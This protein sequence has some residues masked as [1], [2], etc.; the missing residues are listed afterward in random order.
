MVAVSWSSLHLTKMWMLVGIAD[1]LFCATVPV[2]AAGDT[3]PPLDR[4]SPLPPLHFPLDQRGPEAV[5]SLE[6]LRSTSSASS[7]QICTCLVAISPTL[8]KRTKVCESALWFTLMLTHQGP[9]MFPFADGTCCSVSLQDGL[10]HHIYTQ[11][12]EGGVMGPACV[13]VVCMA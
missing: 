6:H 4:L 9:G 2:P 11:V 13:C 12:M 1:G 5:S 10:D 7:A 3:H 8:Q